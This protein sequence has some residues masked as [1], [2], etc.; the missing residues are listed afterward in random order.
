MWGRSGVMAEFTCTAWMAD[1]RAWSTCSTRRVS[2]YIFIG[3]VA[4]S[5]TA[6]TSWA[7]VL[8]EAS[9]CI[10]V[11]KASRNEWKSWCDRNNR[12]LG[13]K[14]AASNLLVNFVLR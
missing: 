7:L 14:K 13:F 3:N 8:K 9:T 11:V 12:C 4:T 2:P 10:M 6:Y 1:L 5:P